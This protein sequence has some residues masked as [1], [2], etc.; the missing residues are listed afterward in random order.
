MA[1]LPVLEEQR[2]DGNNTDTVDDMCNKSTVVDCEEDSSV[3]LKYKKKNH[4]RMSSRMISRV[5][6]TCFVKMNE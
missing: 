2:L 1:Y 3:D 5:D 6:K 4:H